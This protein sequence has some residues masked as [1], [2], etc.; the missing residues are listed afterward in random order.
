[1][2]R[3]EGFELEYVIRASHDDWDRYL[4]DNWYS[5]MRW[6]EENP[7]HP[8]RGQVYQ[9]LRTT[10]DDYA[11]FQRQYLGWAMYVLA[12]GEPTTPDRG[13]VA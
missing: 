7:D 10:Q 5:L 9:R 3:E 11:Q 1:M 13:N 8:D 12:P 6:L 2:T 4:S